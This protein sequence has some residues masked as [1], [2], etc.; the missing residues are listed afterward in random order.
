MK[1]SI[2]T[3]WLCLGVDTSNV[4]SSMLILI[5]PKLTNIKQISMQ[6]TVN[7]WANGMTNTLSH[8][9]TYCTDDLSDVSIIR[10]PTVTND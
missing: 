2:N 7:Y 3:S 8:K 5:L 4:N 1:Q 10:L 9:R 6:L